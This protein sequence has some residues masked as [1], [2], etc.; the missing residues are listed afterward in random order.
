MKRLLLAPLKVNN[1]KSI[2]NKGQ[3][4]TRGFS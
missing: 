3:L 2:Y 4:F 1:W